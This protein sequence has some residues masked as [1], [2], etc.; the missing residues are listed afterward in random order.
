MIEI[1]NHI[2]H[3]KQYGNQEDMTTFQAKCADFFQKGIYDSDAVDICIGAT[4]NALGV[5]VHVLQKGNDKKLHLSSYECLHS[6]STDIYLH[7]YPSKVRG[8]SLDAHFNCYVKKDYYKRIPSQL[9]H[10]LLELMKA[11]WSPIQLKLRIKGKR[12][13]Y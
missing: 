3:Y 1:N 6:S 4:A 10:D 9:R 11:A 5:N 2:T 13:L 8:K 7:H 12:M